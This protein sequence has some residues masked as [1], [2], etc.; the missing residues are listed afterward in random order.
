MII[1]L[2][3]LAYGNSL[4]GDFILDDKFFTKDNIYIKDFS[5]ISKIFRSDIGAGAAYET[6]FYRPLQ[7]ITFMVD[8]SLW[9]SNVKGYH[10]VN[11]LLHVLTA[12][13]LYFFVTLLFKDELLSLFTAI[14]FVTHPIHTEA[15]SY[16]S[17]RADPL[18]A[19]FMLL[20]FISYLRYLHSERLGTYIL[21]ILSYTLALLSREHSLILPV[22]L[23]LYHYSFPAKTTGKKLKLKGAAPILGISLLYILFRVTVL[24]PLLPHISSTSTLLERIPGFFV[25]ISNYIRLI[26]LPFNLHMEY[27]NG[28]FNLTNPKAIP[29]ILI[30]FSL[31]FY[32]F[33]KRHSNNLISFSIFWF[34]IA[35]LPQS[36]IYPINAYMAEHWLYLPS[37][38]F[39]LILA[40]GL[41]SV[42]RA[43][44]FKIIGVLFTAC[45]LVFYLY[46]TIRQNN[47]WR[48]PLTFYKKTLEYTPSTWK[49]YN[50][51]G[52]TYYSMGKI[53]EAIASYK[54][55]IGSNPGHARAYNNLG[56]AYFDT[57]RVGEAI[58]L[59]K[60]AIGIDPD[61]ARAHYN[62]GNAYGSIGKIEE[63]IASY[64]KAIEIRPDYPRTYNNLGNTYYSVGRTKEAIALYKKTIE[65]A[66]RNAEAYN[67]LGVVYY[68]LGRIEEAIALYKKAVEIEPGDGDAHN[69]LAVAYYH[70]KQYGSAIR[71]CDRAIEL[72]CEINPGFLERLRLYRK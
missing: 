46:L 56:S 40:K 71:H 33:R 69:N 19:V 11:I 16:I 22:L 2:G 45:L 5:N 39:F 7:M 67:N 55:A 20:C 24:R 18:S 10:L 63:A 70:N 3:F 23:L 47:Y 38:G 54:K 57:G 17:G 61:D 60:K 14:L 8:Y 52:N 4:D 44:D 35:L 49:V 48:E 68:G 15:I 37:I 9:K 50:N 66:P 59:H 21:I 1:V 26:L 34:F 42:C 28:I 41:S 62:L 25:A 13:C 31:L 51:L 43:K 36:N 12:I 27:G 65:I 6:N 64:K 32:A 72:G 58:V 53:E 30:I 29:G